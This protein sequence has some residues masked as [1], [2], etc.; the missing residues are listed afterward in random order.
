MPVLVNC[1][2]CQMQVNVPDALLGQTVRCA[3]CGGTF[4]A[5]VAALSMGHADLTAMARGR[6]DQ[7]GKTPTQIGRIIGCLGV[8]VPFAIFGLICLLTATGAGLFIMAR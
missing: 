1:P 7:S 4:T 6:M 5:G 8:A 3:A 2:H